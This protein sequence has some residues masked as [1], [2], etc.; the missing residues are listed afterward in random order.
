MT[1]SENFLT[2]DVEDW[3]QSTLD[4][5][6][7]ITRRVCENTRRILDILNRA[8]VQGTFFVLGLVAERF[9][10]IVREII[11]GG[12]EVASHGQSHRPVHAMTPEQFRADLRLSLRSIEDAAGE[13]VLGY[14]APDFSIP[15]GALWAM[16]ILAE[17]G[18]QY[19]SSI[20]PIAGPRYGIRAAFTA[21]F[22]VRCS[23][24]LELLEFPLLTT[25]LLGFRL[26]AAGGGYFRL[27]P[28]AHTRRAIVRMNRNGHPATTYFHPYEIDTQEIPGSEHAIPMVLRLSQGLGRRR[29]R[30]RLMRLLGQFRWGAIRNWLG[31]RQEICSNRVLDLTT[32]HGSTPRWS[33]SGMAGA[34]G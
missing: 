13:R 14:R 11:N 2:F 16:Q 19:D 15:A 4:P 10:E 25:D 8:G 21:P 34:G 3:H 12:H 20:F 28:Y 5:D 17:E 33:S 24:N 1:V 23:R 31:K 9:P 27:L 26:P 30:V 18:L 7:P 29:T 6:L 22:L 32:P